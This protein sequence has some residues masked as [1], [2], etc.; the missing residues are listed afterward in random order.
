LQFDFDLI[1][2]KWLPSAPITRVFM[3][4]FFLFQPLLVFTFLVTSCHTTYQSQSVKYQDYRITQKQPASNEITALLK[5]YSDSVNNSMNGVVAVAG[6][7][8]EKK[9][10]EGTLGNVLADAMLLMAKE[11]YQTN[12]DGALINF[13]GIRLPSI[14]SGD[15]A[16]G[17]IYEVA[18]FDNIIVLLKLNGRLLQQLLNHI[19]AKGGWPCAGMS[20][21]IKNKSAVNI[22]IAGN[23]LDENKEYSIALLDYIANGGDDCEML[24]T[25]P[26][27]N[28]GYLFR[29]A[30]IDYFAK[31][32]KEG[33]KITA[34]I[35]KRVT[36]AE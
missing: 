20:W 16:L 9:Q 7:T 31:L 14:P 4:K 32:N 23:A 22:I 33:K 35:E 17:K 10:P 36:N 30:V 19:A 15:I 11:K 8:L 12:I 13:G 27:Q 2:E 18:P 29:D 5:P 25:I 21:Q 28:N 34:S 1:L 3:R 24:K 26:Q 6:M